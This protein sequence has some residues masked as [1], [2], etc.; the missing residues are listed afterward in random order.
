MHLSTGFVGTGHLNNV[1]TETGH[2]DVAYTLL[3][4]R[5]YPSWLYPVEQGAT[6]IWERWNS[7]T[8]ESGFGDRSMNSFNHYSL[9]A[10]GE[11]LY[12]TVLGIRAAE[13]G[14]KSLVIRPIPGGKLT[15]ANGSYHSIRGLIRCAWETTAGG[16][17]LAV[18]V[19]ANTS[20]TVCVPASDAA[21]ITESGKPAASAEGVTFLRMENGHAIY[22]VGSGR[23]RFFARN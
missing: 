21:K 17:D 22:Q 13:P 19:P 23:Y 1:L 7:W 4:Q 15:K 5:T 16:F 11:W 8:K 18:E 20:A 3:C 6:T 9:G 12:D 10:C 14:F 2:T